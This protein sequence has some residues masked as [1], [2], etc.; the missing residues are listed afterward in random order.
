M[1]EDLRASVP[2]AVSTIENPLPGSSGVVVPRPPD[3]ASMLLLGLADNIPLAGEYL[4]DTEDHPEHSRSRSRSPLH[5]FESS[6]DSSGVS[7]DSKCNIVKR[8]CEM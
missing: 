1:S 2:T 8:L 7:I 5:P 6:D 3:H 4:V